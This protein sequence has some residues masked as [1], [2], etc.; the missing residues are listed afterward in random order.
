MIILIFCLPNGL[1]C[2]L[3]SMKIFKGGVDI[4]PLFIKIKFIHLEAHLC[5][6]ERDKLESVLIKCWYL[7]Q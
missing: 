1:V 2:Q 4:L 7:I 5:S 3:I 6:I